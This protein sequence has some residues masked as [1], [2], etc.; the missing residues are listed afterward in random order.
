MLFVATELA[1]EHN[2][3]KN[4]HE[5]R[6]SVCANALLRLCALRP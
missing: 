1:N 6:A 2:K 5:A 3:G 4:F